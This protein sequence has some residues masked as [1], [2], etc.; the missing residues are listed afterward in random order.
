MFIF[1][2]E[3][4]IYRN[5]IFLNENVN[6]KVNRWKLKIQHLNFDIEY[7]PRNENVVANLFSRALEPIQNNVNSINN[8]QFINSINNPFT[9]DD[10]TYK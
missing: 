10:I 5:L 7:I 2:L 8:I 9:I 3:P 4:I 6:I 1:V